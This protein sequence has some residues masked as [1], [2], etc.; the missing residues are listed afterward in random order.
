MPPKI[1]GAFSPHSGTSKKRPSPSPKSGLLTTRSSTTLPFLVSLTSASR[2]SLALQAK[3]LPTSLPI[4][5]MVVSLGTGELREGGGA[6]EEAEN[7]RDG[8]HAKRRARPG[9]MPRRRTS[10]AGTAF[11]GTGPAN[12]VTWYTGR[13]AP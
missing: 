4:S 11:R 2:T 7:E 8:D 5:A 6:E 10:A 3:M 9:E 13:P 1:S 12:V